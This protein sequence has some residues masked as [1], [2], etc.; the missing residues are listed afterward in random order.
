LLALALKILNG[1]LPKVPADAESA[2]VNIV[3]VLFENVTEEGKAATEAAL[4][5]E[6]PSTWP[7]GIT[8]DDWTTYTKEDLLACGG[9]PVTE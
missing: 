6:L 7:V 5:P 9:T 4:D 2:V 3:P 1:E 8:V